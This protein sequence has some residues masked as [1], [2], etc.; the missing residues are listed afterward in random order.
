MKRILSGSL[1]H[2]APTALLRLVSATSP[3]GVLELDTADGSLRLDVDRGRVRKP[4]RS[5]LESAGQILACRRGEFRFS[6]HGVPPHE[7]EVLS[8]TAFAEAAAGAASNL[9]VD[10]LLNEELLEISQ[11]LS[12]ANIHVL[13]S[14]PPRNPLG[15]LLADLKVEAPTGLLVERVGIAVQ[16]PEW[17]RESLEPEWRRRGWQVCHF[18]VVEDVD[19]D[20]ID[21]LVVDDRQ[22]GSRAGRQ[23]QWLQ[24]IQSA[25]AA[26]PSLPVVW[27]TALD[28]VGWVHRL[29]EAGVSFLMPAP[30]GETSE[31][32]ARFGD[33]LS[34]VVERHLEAR[35]NEGQSG[36]PPGVTE[37][38]GALLSEDDPDQGISSLL[39]LAAEHFERGAVLMAEETVVRCRAG[40]GYPLNRDH[41]QLPREVGLIEH[42]IRTGEA[43]MAV[44]PEAEEVGGLADVLGVDALPA[45][46]AVIPLGRSGGVAGILVA[47]RQG[48]ELPDLDDLVLLAGRLGGAAVR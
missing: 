43:V 32:M 31:I 10:R 23:G 19:I 8:L 42:V 18:P 41:T 5:E 39:Q 4:S 16:H 30:Q 25:A 13:P 38:V 33:G 35:R 11:P 28:D 24:L 9:E 36:L 26:N 45:A 12:R 22:A 44:D 14:E 40:F 7:G 15:D 48:R 20:A 27:V 37:L 21:L 1:E 2:L 6:P 29:I 47:D 3:S 34:L 46:A 17:W